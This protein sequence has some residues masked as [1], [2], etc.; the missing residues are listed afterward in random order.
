MSAAT[1]AFRG[2]KRAAAMVVGLFALTGALRA[3]DAPP[4]TAHDAADA[5]I[6]HPR[7]KDHP[8]EFKPDYEDRNAWGWRAKAL[9]DQVQVALGLWPMPERGPITPVIHGKIDRDAY[10]VEKVYFAS[11]PGC[12]VTGNLY[13]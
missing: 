6:A 12:Y 2:W 4:T 13:R 9:H 10:T 8:V 5:R 11:L 7:D 1:K 3:A